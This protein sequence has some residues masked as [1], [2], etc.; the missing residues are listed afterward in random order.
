MSTGSSISS[1]SSRGSSGSCHSNSSS[2]GGS[3]TSSSAVVVVVVVVGVTQR[4]RKSAL[5][6]A[7][8]CCPFRVLHVYPC[9]KGGMWRKKRNYR[10]NSP[11]DP[12]TAKPRL[13]RPQ[14]AYSSTHSNAPQGC[15]KLAS[16][17]DWMTGH[18]DTHLH[19]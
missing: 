2:S 9:T 19:V 3:G 8:Q 18:T 16:R 11:C 17:L 15:S 14:H 12:F 4:E 1:S 5:P 13:I 6:R 7:L 10:T